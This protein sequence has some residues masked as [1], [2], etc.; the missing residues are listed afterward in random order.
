MV[1]KTPFHFS[2]IRGFN[3]LEIDSRV[4]KNTIYSKFQLL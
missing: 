4:R 2:E 1:G 3:L